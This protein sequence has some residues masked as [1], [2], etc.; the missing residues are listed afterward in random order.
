MNKNSP[1]VASFDAT[2]GFAFGRS[3]IGDR[4]GIQDTAAVC[5]GVDDVIGV[6]DMAE[7]LRSIGRGGECED[8]DVGSVECVDSEGVAL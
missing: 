2:T 4:C 5:S 8:A 7:V 6:T 1:V 3:N